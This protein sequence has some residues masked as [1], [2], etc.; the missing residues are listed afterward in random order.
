M[1]ESV[2]RRIMK[3]IHVHRGDN[4]RKFKCILA[5]SGADHSEAIDVSEQY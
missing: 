2:I 5:W 3:E 4:R 1:Q